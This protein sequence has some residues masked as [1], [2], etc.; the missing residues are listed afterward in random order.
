MRK[1][2][3]SL[4]SLFALYLTSFSQNVSLT[5]G[6]YTQDFN[7]LSN[8]AGSTTNNLTITGWF[9]TESG[10]GARDNEQYAVDPG[11]SNTGD[12][13]SYGTAA[14]TE[15]AL[16]GLRSG[17]LI[18]IF[19][20]GFTN[21]T[22][23]TITELN[24]AYTG[25]QW[26]LGTAARTDQINF[27]YSLNATNLVTGS[28]TAV[29]TLNFVTPVT[30][31]TGA[32]DGNAAANRTALT[33]NITG[34]SIPNG[35][36][37][38]IRWTDT[39]A[40]GADDGL[41]VDDFSITPTSSGGGGG[42][43]LSIND[44][45]I[46][47]GN[48]GTT[49]AVF[50]VSL[51]APAG[52]GG[53][54]F[55]IATADGT[56]TIASN[57]YVSNSLTSQTIPPGSSNYTFTVQ[58]NGDATVEP[59][60]NY[61]V[62][63]TNVTG[64]TVTDGQGQGTITNDDVSL[65]FIHDIQGNGN[66]SPLNGLSI[67]TR[68][69][70]TGVRSNGFFIQEPDATIDADPNTSEGIFVFTSSAPPA[71]VAVGNLVQVAGTVT[72]FI[73][74][75]DPNSPSQT[76]LISPTVSLLS[77][78]NPLPAA[79]VLTAADTDPAGSI[80]QLEKFESMRVQVNSL[81][82]IAP[83]QG[84]VSEPNAT[85]TSNGFFY[86]VITGIN[87][88]FREPGIIVP[89]P[90]PGG[91]PV[92][93]PRY[94]ANPEKLGVGSSSIGGTAINVATGAI[95][96]NVVGP[97][98][99]RSRTY[100]I[101]IDP[102]IPPVVS[103]NGL[104]FTAVP[105][106]T[107]DELTVASFNVE[108]FYDDVNDPGGDVALTTTAYNNR[109]NKVSLAIRNVLMTPDVIGMVEVEKLSALQAIADKVNNDVVA[110]GGSNPGYVAFLVEGNDPGGI[111][112]GFLVKSTRVTVNSVTQYGLNAT[113]TEPGGAV[114]LL[115]DRPP[116]V[117]NA[118]FTGS[119][120]TGNNNF[121]VIANHLRSL[122]G[123][124]DPVDGNRVRTKRA[125]QAE[126]LADLI[127]GFQLADPNA[128]IVSVGDFNAFQFNDGY[129][130]L[131]G[132]IKGD[133]TPAANVTLASPDLVN[134]DLIDLV[135]S[136]SAS[137]RYSYSFS[138]DAQVLDHIIINANLSNKISRFAFARLDADFP[139]IYRS[140]ANRPERISDHDAP[141]AYI[142]FRDATNPT[143]TCPAATTV[144]CSSAVPA[145]DINAVTASDNCGSVTVT[146]QGDVIS[147]QT[148]TNRYTITRTYRA[149]DAAGN[150]AEC[151]Q[152]ITVN[153]QTAP[154]I[155]CPAN[156]TVSCA[157]AVPAVNTGDVTAT[158]NCG[159]TIIITHESDVISAQTCANRYTITRTYRATDICGNFSECTQ[160]IT[161]NDQTPPV[162]TCPVNVIVSCASAVPAVNTGAVT[163]T[164]N[165]AGTITI[166]HVG[167]V[168]SAQTCANRYTITR[169]YRATDV[170]GNFS[171][172]TQIITVND[173]TAPV[174]T[175]PAA[176]TVSCASAVPAVNTGAVTATDNCA[177]VITIIHVGDVITNQTCAN[178]YTI[179]RTYRAT[180]VCGNSST[181]TQIITVNDQTAPVLTCPANISVTTPVGQ[182]TAVVNFTPTATDNCGGAVTIT[183]VPASGFAFPIGVTTVNVTATDA[184]GN[185]STCSFTVTVADGQLPVISQQPQTGFVCEGSNATFSVTAS[186]ARSY[187]W[188]QWNGSSWVNITG[189]TA[190]SF[191]V[192]NVSI[193]QNAS[194]YR[195]AVIG[196][197]TTVQSAAAILYVNP[198]PSV[199]ITPSI[200]TAILPGQSL[201]LNTVVSPAGG[202][203]AWYY[204]NTL[205][206]TQNGSSWQNITVDGLGT[207]YVRYTNLDGCSSNSAS[208][209]VSAQVTDRLWI[210][211]N[212]NNGR[213]Q[214]R[215]YNQVNEQV[216]VTVYGINGQQIYQRSF[217]AG[218]NYSRL[219]IVLGGSAIPGFYVVEVRNSQ[220]QLIGR[221]PIIIRPS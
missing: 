131:I 92:T 85:A 172:C 91:A 30:A 104:T 25:E 215:F 115:N 94:D 140:D 2:Y 82:V 109:L 124:D 42:S 105:A 217:V 45:S 68:G 139:E 5:G 32:K 44:V 213:F 210:Y 193:T 126:F 52:A 211:P 132:T 83:T 80:T 61:F 22:G 160:I 75:T 29:A 152:I 174:I 65:S 18:P 87:R 103:N 57:D 173:E 17:T 157:S 158:D 127:Q 3:L 166:T 12:T 20:G 70:V 149:T 181:C 60:E 88:P 107:T 56:A 119:A 24:I 163:A 155:T 95:L 138:G 170:C 110:G 162:I 63:V 37:F 67:T 168:I 164:D 8:T 36:S 59:N 15:R 71:A 187:Q 192:P 97:L 200:P 125:R 130:D 90:L 175:C 186:N 190:S 10:G 165:C 100:T 62:N 74:T 117:L 161:V 148:C 167:D 1:I 207:Y 53:V 179:T 26:R 99:Y 154:V 48:A 169:T 151:T 191:T 180:D 19:G 51:S 196:L 197:C 77:A 202:S 118:T 221:K 78:G 171:E 120:C 206:P 153:D 144:S 128:N 84:N 176:V 203:Y 4:V 201:N 147:G 93:I 198:L 86:G 46:V 66:S 189:A 146:H 27:E 40:S 113:Y 141:V 54:T 145:A 98:D 111:D 58:I 55:D 50:T 134:P 11:S 21:N 7:T 35:A 178:R 209:V 177:G 205:V 129:A 185:S 218:N 9:M 108:R 79:I 38:Y 212:P 184:C 76:E 49:N 47:E 116:L 214:V 34:L 133:P 14:S 204:N 220:G 122:N 114:S 208:V 219:D 69:I 123:I 101:D 43:N 39:D 156:V 89:D 142:L 72:E 199:N 150:F 64:A 112:V 96:T 106:Q 73:P 182:C 31:T 13:Y 188:Q 194:T 102:A 137:D 195:V 41:S 33:A 135:D 143:I 216:T 121:I 81:T 16:G 6:T 159:G 23:G 28:W 183:S 136:H